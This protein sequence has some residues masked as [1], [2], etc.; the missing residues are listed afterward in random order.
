[1]I[2][3]MIALRM[4]RILCLLIDRQWLVMAGAAP[5]RLQIG[6]LQPGLS[7]AKYA[8]S[9]IRRSTATRSKSAAPKQDIVQGRLPM[10]DRG[11]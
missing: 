9:A 7:A 1:M 5:V 6:K 10:R 4:D 3:I 2:E 11:C 8:T